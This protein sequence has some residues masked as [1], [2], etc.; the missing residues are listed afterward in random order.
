MYRIGYIL[1]IPSI[2][3][4][5]LAHRFVG[6][7][8]TVLGLFNYPSAGYI[9]NTRRTVITIANHSLGSFSPS[10]T[11]FPFLIKGVASSA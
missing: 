9:V 3:S 11:V 4:S 5:L 7:R 10:S 6:F 1:S 2:L 8:P